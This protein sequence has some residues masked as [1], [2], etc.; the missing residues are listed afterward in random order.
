MVF[1]GVLSL[2][3]GIF[4]QGYSSFSI[5]R[6][7]DQWSQYGLFDFILPFLLIFALVFGILSAMNLFKDNKAVNGIIA[8]AIGLMS[9][10]FGIVQ[11]FFAELFPRF[12]VG[13]AIFLVFLILAGFFID[14]KAAL[15]R[16][17]LV[18]VGAIIVV[19]ILINTAGSLNIG[20]AYWWY[21]NWPV[22]ALGVFLVI[23]I[24][25][26]IGGSSGPKEFKN[27]WPVAP[28]GS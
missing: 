25:V 24:G 9:L 21:D 28:V 4:L 1:E 14:P 10:Q 17:I 8:L 19:V 12:G 15:F 11:V 20:A 22:V 13:L 2:A 26:I 3:N 6:V 27:W 7:L 5:G 18:G 23:I 16:W